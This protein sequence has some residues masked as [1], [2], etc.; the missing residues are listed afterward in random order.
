MILTGFLSLS[1]LLANF[2]NLYVLPNLQRSASAEK[3]CSGINRRDGVSGERHGYSC[4]HR[5]HEFAYNYIAVEQH[6]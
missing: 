5:P 6:Q 1:T 4:N 3:N 2:R